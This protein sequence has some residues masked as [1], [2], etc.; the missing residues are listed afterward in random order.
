MR[1]DVNDLSA[2]LARDLG[3]PV[4]NL[5]PASVH[6]VFSQMRFFDHR[7]RVVVQGITERQIERAPPR[8]TN[9]GPST[10]LGTS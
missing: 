4:I 9:A 7:P 6:A 3:L 2:R 1:V 8:S 5:A 10:S